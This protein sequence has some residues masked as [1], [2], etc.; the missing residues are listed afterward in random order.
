MCV[1]DGSLPDSCAGNGPEGL[2]QS[3]ALYVAVPRIAAGEVP[4]SVARFEPGANDSLVRLGAIGECGFC[5][6]RVQ[7]GSTSRPFAG[8]FSMSWGSDGY[9][10]YMIW[11]GG[12][13]LGNTA[14]SACSR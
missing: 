6:L 10:L 9:W 11:A 3:S 1:F 4:R 2:L 8:W 14:S 7:G 5:K 13:L 12:L